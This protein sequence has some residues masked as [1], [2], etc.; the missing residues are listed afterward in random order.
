MTTLP[1][2]PTLTPR[3]P[4]WVHAWTWGVFAAI[5]LL[6]AALYYHYRDTDVWYLWTGSELKPRGA[7]NELYRPSIFRQRANTLSNLGFILTGLYVMAYA[8]WDTLR[9][10]PENA[11]Y[12][13]RQPALFGLFGIACFVLGAGSGAMHA[14]VPRGHTM[15]V[16]GMF[17]IFTALIALQWARW[18]P[19]VPFGSRRWPSW[20]IL[21]IAAVIGSVLL[22]NYAH[23]LGGDIFV[24]VSLIVT[25]GVVVCADFVLRPTTQRI[26][27]LVLANFCGLTA[28]YIWL[29]DKDGKFSTPESWLQGH[30]FWHLLQGLALGCMAIFYHSEIPRP[31]R[32]PCPSP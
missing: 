31:T 23:V 25:T 21:A 16:F 19:E 3:A 14:G 26:R 17:F 9:E 7:F 24:F 28:Y 27:W 13:V 1:D 18:I 8:W 2:Q 4:R 15:D 10:P 32:R 29:L 5:S 12:A 6:L 11:P 30:A 22:K 20:P